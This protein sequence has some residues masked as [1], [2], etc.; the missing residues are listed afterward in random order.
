MADGP[1][2][3]DIFNTTYSKAASNTT[4][5]ATLSKGAW[6]GIKVWVFQ[7]SNGAGSLNF[8]LQEILPDN[9]LQSSTI[10][11]IPP[12]TNQANTW[13]GFEIRPDVDAATG[14]AGNKTPNIFKM[15]LP[16]SFK[17]RI[18]TN[19]GGG[20]AGLVKVYYQFLE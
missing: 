11:S 18:N 7:T 6:R 3:G 13:A 16:N 5:V 14:S 19:G 9:T 20:T 2:V 10:G 4:D 17:L 12:L 1:V 8:W 15:I